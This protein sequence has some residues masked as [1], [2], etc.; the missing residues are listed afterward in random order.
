MIVKCEEKGNKD[1]VEIMKKI[2]NI[3][4]KQ[5]NIIEK[6][7]LNEKTYGKAIDSA[8]LSITVI[9]TVVQIFAVFIAL[10]SAGLAYLGLSFRKKVK[11]SKNALEIGTKYINKKI[12]DIDGDTKKIEELKKVTY[13]LF[14]EIENMK[15]EM[16][17]KVVQFDETCREGKKTVQDKMQE[18][19]IEI[20][21]FE[22]QETDDKIKQLEKQFK[23]FEDIGIPDDVKLLSTKA[24]LYFN[25]EMY[26]ESL[27][28]NT[29]IVEKDPKHISAY[30]Y[31]GYI[32]YKLGRYEKSME[33]YSQY[34]NINTRNATVYNNRALVFIKLKKLKE[35]FDDLANAINIDNTSVLFYRNM[36]VYL[37]KYNTPVVNGLL[38]KYINLGLKVE[39]N[40][41][42]YMLEICRVLGVNKESA[43]AAKY[44]DFIL[45]YYRETVL[46]SDVTEGDYLNYY[47]I[48]VS[49]NKFDEIDSNRQKID[50]AIQEPRYLLIYHYLKI[51]ESIKRDRTIDI[52]PAVQSIIQD[53]ISKPLSAKGSWNF[54]DI[55]PSIKELFSD[56]NIV[57]K[58][59][60][61][62]QSMF[63]K[64]SSID[65][66]KAY[67]EEIRRRH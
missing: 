47:E 10:F 57:L 41:V 16:K 12:K 21:S 62:I 5:L 56:D 38:E 22:H 17:Q 34:L 23:V 59:L 24:E 35:A 7:D 52:T 33:A 50:L 26:V 15:E 13:D 64:T 25:K 39:K 30:W 3:E 11:R 14:I 2:N 44:T 58:D 20:S 43:L 1:Y 66:C 31:I 42:I 48:L 65:D 36:V 9:G 61:F 37:Y 49:K 40:N 28:L 19:L 54:E 67:I 6:T 51:I 60:L 53:F 55:N 8:N 32:Q 45:N 4:N 29:K 63:N 27:L 46:S 18:K